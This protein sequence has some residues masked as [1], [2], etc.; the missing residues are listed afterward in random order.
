M[1]ITLSLDPDDAAELRT[2]AETEGLSPEAVVHQALK[3]LLTERTGTAQKPT[4]SM[5]GYLAKYGS[6]PS[7]QD[8]DENRREMFASFGRDDIA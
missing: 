3:R 7:E 5:L 4:R 1:N 6:G 8:I 2:R